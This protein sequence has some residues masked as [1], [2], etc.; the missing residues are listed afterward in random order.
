MF[1]ILTLSFASLLLAF[2]GLP[3]WTPSFHNPLR[4]RPAAAVDS[5]PPAWKPASRL[6][7]EDQFVTGALPTLAPKGAHFK[8]GQDPRQLRVSLDP[9]TGRVRYG[10]EFGNVELGQPVSIPLADLSHELTQLNFE[11]LWQTT[12][13]DKINTMAGHTDASSVGRTGLSFAIPSPLPQKVQN[14]LGPGGPALNVSGSEQIRLSGTS[15]WTNQQ[16]GLLGQHRSLFPSLDMQ[17]DLNIVLEGQ[18]SD[19]VKVN[20]LQNSA[21]Q[22]PLANRIAINY[23]GDED[24]L[25]QSLD[26]GNTNLTLPGTQYV[27][28]SGRNEGLFGAKLSSRLGPLDLTLLA[29]KQEGRSER[30]SYAGGSQQQIQ[31]IADLDYVKGVYYL[32]Y[33]PSFDLQ[34]PYQPS[35]QLFVDEGIYTNTIGL[36]RG[37]AW[38]D[39]RTADPTRPDTARV[40][41]RGNFKPLLAGSDYDFEVYPDVYG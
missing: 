2:P 18:L 28:Y 38:L 4:H 31:E 39:P 13:H 35:I 23:K 1:Q 7:L 10:V 20:L 17:Q 9:E 36:V 21:V 22:I 24:D 33:D 37:R 3:N 29:S 11:R 5:L 15:N 16:L 14:L 40:A 34:Y 30:A 32:L 27:S 19:R 26:L 41:L 6:A 25:V 8:L 12:S